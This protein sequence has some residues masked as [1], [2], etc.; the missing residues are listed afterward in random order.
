VLQLATPQLSRPL[1][2]ETSN[3]S[4]AIVNRSIIARLQK[5]R[6]SDEFLILNGWFASPLSIRFQVVPFDQQ[7]GRLTNRR[8]IAVQNRNSIFKL[9]RRLLLRRV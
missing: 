8:F 1:N 7:H 6:G 2:D 9:A 5:P 3:P 4:G